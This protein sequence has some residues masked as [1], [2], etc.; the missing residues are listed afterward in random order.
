MV[1]GPCLACNRICNVWT[2]GSFPTKARFK[3]PCTKFWNFCCYSTMFFFYSDSVSKLWQRRAWV[4][5][6]WNKKS[7]WISNPEGLEKSN[8]PPKGTTNFKFWNMKLLLLLITSL[9]K[10]FKVCFVG[11]EVMA[12]TWQ[13]FVSILGLR[14]NEFSLNGLFQKI[15]TH[16]LWTTLN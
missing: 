15:S 6:V 5:K 12:K 11:Y 4:L 8:F 13:H 14:L 16:P 7:L 1:S 3:N 2:G 10:Y 9:Q